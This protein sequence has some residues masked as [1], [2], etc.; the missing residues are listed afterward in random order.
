MID[1]EI[2]NFTR[3]LT[4]LAT[5]YADPSI[6]L[7]QVP[8][9]KNNLMLQQN[10]EYLAYG[11]GALFVGLFALRTLKKRRKRNEKNIAMVM[12]QPYLGDSDHSNTDE[13]APA[14]FDT[15]N[16]GEAHNLASELTV[17][18]SSGVTNSD[19]SQSQQLED[20]SAI[21]FA[22]K[23]AFTPD[24]ARARVMI[25]AALNEFGAG[26]MIMA[27]TALGALIAPGSEAVG[28]ER[29]HAIAAIADKY[30]DFAIFDRA[31]RCILALDVTNG[32]PAIGN[33]ALERAV[34]HS[35]LG[36]AGL[37]M[38]N[39]RTSDTPADVRSKI[40]GYLKPIAQGQPPRRPSAVNPKSNKA[41][42]PG[43]PTRP[44][45]AAHAAAIAAE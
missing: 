40:A 44:V 6:I 20:V 4:H 14:S 9:L 30:L 32:E 1:Q 19:R 43:R 35:A 8:V 21:R 22:S 33:K 23:S 2:A 45:R 5:Q 24:E 39:L 26:Y 41:P 42:R 12:P 31:G 15:D 38:A 37:P 16:F 25:Q 10:P 7:Q 27:R 17:A 3:T 28:P 11:I 13:T 29:A 36:Q 34:V 18:E